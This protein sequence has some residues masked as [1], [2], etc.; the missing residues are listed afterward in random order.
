MRGRQQKIRNFTL[1]LVEKFKLEGLGQTLNIV[2]ELIGKL[3]NKGKL[4]RI[5]KHRF[6]F[7]VEV[8]KGLETRY[9]IELL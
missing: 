4:N 1:K 3:N 2:E 9:I 8:K 5:E 6:D 7:L